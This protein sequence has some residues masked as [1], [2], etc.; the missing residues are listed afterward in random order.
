[1]KKLDPVKM[2]DWE[3]AEAASENMKTVTQ[4]AKELG[5]RIHAKTGRPVGI[6]AINTQ[7]GVA[8]KDYVGKPVTLGIRAENIEVQREDGDTATLKI[9]LQDGR[10][11]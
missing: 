10:V 9:E 4:L 2:K 6:I 3:I 7:G 1:M 11:R 5:D 8:L